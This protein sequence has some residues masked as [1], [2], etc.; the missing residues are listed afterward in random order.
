MRIF[1]RI[2]LYNYVLHYMQLYITILSLDSNIFTKFRL[3]NCGA[4][5]ITMNGQNSLDE[6]ISCPKYHTF[7]LLQVDSKIITK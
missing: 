7:L 5:N 3:D 4:Q 2:F 1:K 6:M